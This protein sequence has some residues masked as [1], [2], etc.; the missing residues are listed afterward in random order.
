[1][2]LVGPSGCG[3]TTLL[4]V[5]LGILEPDNGNIYFEN[6]SLIDIPIEKRNIGFVPQDFGLFPHLSVYKNI[7]YGLKIRKLMQKADSRVKDL[8]SILKLDGLEERKPNQLSWGQKQRAALARA[9]AFN[10]TLLLLDEPMS[11]IDWR[12]REEILK[13]IKDIQT[14]LR[15]TTVYVTHNMQEALELGQ[16]VTIMHEGRFEQC[17]PPEILLKN[18][19]TPFVTYFLSRYKA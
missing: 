16:R 5:I 10:P 4:N 19:K 14:N 9:L 3:K 13:E 17:D 1:M 2:V 8:I 18:P 15:I 7:I 12:T 6:Q 11:A